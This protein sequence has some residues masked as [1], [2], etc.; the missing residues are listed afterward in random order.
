ML[1]YETVIESAGNIPIKDGVVHV[2]TKVILVPIVMPLSK[3]LK[4][5]VLLLFNV[6]FP[7]ELLLMIIL[8]FPE[9][10]TSAK[11]PLVKS[12]D[13]ILPSGKSIPTI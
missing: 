6:T 11:F 7:K 1:L 10:Y 13:A 2:N 3:K 8:P 9:Y 12:N 5:D 4:T